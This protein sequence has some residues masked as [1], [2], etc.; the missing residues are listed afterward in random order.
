MGLCVS[1]PNL[2]YF[3]RPKSWVRLD[4]A[5]FPRLLHVRRSSSCGQPAAVLVL[6]WLWT[7]TGF[8]DLYRH[9]MASKYVPIFGCGLSIAPI[10]KPLYRLGQGFN[11]SA[12]VSKHSSQPSNPRCGFQPTFIL[13]ACS[14]SRH[15]VLAGGMPYGSESISIIRVNSHRS[16]FVFRQ[17]GL[18]VAKPFPKSMLSLRC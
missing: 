6:I 18:T 2:R 1:V 17:A 10:W 12:A 3:M 11:S 5:N 13:S 9:T 7:L 14:P 8:W 15:H 4:Q 16:K